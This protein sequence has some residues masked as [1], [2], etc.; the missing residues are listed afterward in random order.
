MSS[1]I[2]VTSPRLIVGPLRRMRQQQRGRQHE[3][4][5]RQPSQ[6]ERVAGDEPQAVPAVF[7]EPALVAVPLIVEGL[8][9]LR[10]PEQAQ[11]VV[12]EVRLD[13]EQAGGPGAEPDHDGQGPDPASGAYASG[14]AWPGPDA[15]VRGDH[16]A[17]HDPDPVV[18]PAD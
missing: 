10:D 16:D 13:V 9:V 3:R 18:I 17:G 7:G 12:A 2:W 1:L 11:R 14:S 4:E 15:V 6:Y 5:H 8:R